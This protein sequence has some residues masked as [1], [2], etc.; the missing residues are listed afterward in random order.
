[1]ID[2]NE[3]QRDDPETA[4]TFL[5]EQA[6]EL[7]GTVSAETLGMLA[8]MQSDYPDSY[9]RFARTMKSEGIEVVGEYS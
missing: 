2:Y 1:M 7:G 8:M 6:A 5:R 3:I 9:Q 4:L